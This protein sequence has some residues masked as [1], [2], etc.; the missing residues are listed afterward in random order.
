MRFKDHLT[1]LF[2]TLQMSLLM[3]KI[4]IINTSTSIRNHIHRLN[5]IA[6]IIACRQ[7]HYQKGKHGI[8]E[9][10]KYMKEMRIWE[11][12]SNQRN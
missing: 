7:F 12:N 9:T 8:K 2:Y 5:E 11:E 3:S 6:E 4:I 1:L 10:N